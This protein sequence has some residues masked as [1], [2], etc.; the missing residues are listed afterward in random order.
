[1]QL[2]ELEATNDSLADDLDKATAKIF[3][4]N[5]EN[6]SLVGKHTSLTEDLI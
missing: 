4:L 3:E 1:M 6:E 2:K 5:S